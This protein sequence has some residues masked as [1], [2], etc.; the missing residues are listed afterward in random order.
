MLDYLV[1]TSAN[2]RQTHYLCIL[3]II[4]SYNPEQKWRETYFKPNV[5][6]SPFLTVAVVYAR[7]TWW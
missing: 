7:C 4:K 1:I 2:S 3:L 5:T 6:F